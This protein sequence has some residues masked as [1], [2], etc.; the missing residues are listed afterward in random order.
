MPRQVPVIETLKI[1]ISQP[2][3][4][5]LETFFTEAAASQVVEVINEIYGAYDSVEELRQAYEGEE[6]D[7]PTDDNLEEDE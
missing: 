4:T 1:I 7:M 3:G 5:V 2:N 6:P